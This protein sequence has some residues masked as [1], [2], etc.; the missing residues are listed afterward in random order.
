[1]LLNS[2]GDAEWL[3]LLPCFLFAA[4][5]FLRQGVP[6][7]NVSAGQ[8]L[9]GRYWCTG[10]GSAAGRERVRKQSLS[11]LK[12]HLLKGRLQKLYYTAWL[13]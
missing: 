12:D 6:M 1:M 13:V 11:F 4:Y 2:F 8:P 10:E 7:R 3:M 9:A 5:C